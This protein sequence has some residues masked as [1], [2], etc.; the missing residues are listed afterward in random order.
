MSQPAVEACIVTQP[1]GNHRGGLC[2]ATD[3]RSLEVIG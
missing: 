3:G 1:I 2:Q